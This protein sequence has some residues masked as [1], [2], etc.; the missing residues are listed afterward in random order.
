M[1]RAMSKAVYSKDCNGHFGLSLEFYCHFTSPIRR[2]PDLMIHRIIKDSLHGYS[3][4][5]YAPIV[6]EVAKISS[7]KERL[8]E[9]AERKADDLII[10]RY[11]SQFVG[12]EFDGVVCGVVE[13]GFFV[14]LDNT[15]E[16]VVRT[17][18]LDG[19]YVFDSKAMKLLGKRSIAM[20]EKVRVKLVGA[21]DSRL[22]M[23]LL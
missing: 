20:G 19:S 16:G 14:K 22:L 17:E 8:A 7:Q 12:Q 2:Y 23:K 18:T 21:T 1:L 5:K 4:Q 3:L 11:M 10:C 15:S 6:E 9:E 13:W